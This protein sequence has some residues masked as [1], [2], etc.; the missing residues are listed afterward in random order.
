MNIDISE[1]KNSLKDL[2]QRFR[3]LGGIFDIEGKENRSAQLEKLMAKA[4]FW[5]NPDA[6]RDILKERSELNE[7]I[8]IWRGLSGEIEDNELLFEM[9]MEEA[10]EQ[11]LQEVLR[12]LKELQKRYRELELRQ[13]LN[14][15]YD[16]KNAIVS[17]NAGAGGTEA[18]DWTEMLLRMYL[19]WCERK[20]F[21]VEMIDLLEGEE[22]GVKNVTFTV[23]GP[24]AH[25]MMKAESGVHR[26]V[27]I[28]PF[29]ASG[30]RHTS[31]AAVLVFPE[32][33]DKI[34]VDVKQ[35]DLRVD[36]YRA[37]GAGGQHVNKTSSAVRITHLP[38]GIVV[39]CQNEKSQ[40]RNR[41]IA[42]KILKARLYER[43][44]RAQQ[45]KIQE[46]HD[47]LDEIAWGNQIRSYVMQPY[48]L[49]KDH[50]TN[51]EKGNV[52]SVMDGELDEFIEAYLLNSMSR[53]SSVGAA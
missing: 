32:I 9:A 41:D 52:D 19:R 16:N 13:M 23:S 31:F 18:Q 43:E 27:R 4:D 46:T 8:Q 35:S 29:D 53:E 47:N 49:V 6:S 7:I 17:I 44:R 24:Y 3:T 26:L 42:M 34:E 15:E 11:N 38:T 40:H 50:R 51:V 10:D 45:A 21:K 22:A 36:T 1:L 5:E 20:N 48:R 25:G 37:S 14:D 33:D 12:K 28:S 2:S 30:R 39:A